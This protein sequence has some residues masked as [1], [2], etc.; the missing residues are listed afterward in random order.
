MYYYITFWYFG[1]FVNQNEKQKFVMNRALNNIE[2]FIHAVLMIMFWLYIK[3]L[4]INIVII[5]QL[6]CVY[7]VP[8]ESISSH[9]Y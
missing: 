6:F 8:T 2:R 5:Q 1:N 4:L 3:Q 9:Q 7:K